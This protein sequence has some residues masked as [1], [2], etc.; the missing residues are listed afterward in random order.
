MEHTYISLPHL[1]PCIRG[2]MVY[3][4]FVY[5]SKFAEILRFLKHLGV[6]QSLGQPHY[7]HQVLLDDPASRHQAVKVGE[8][9]VI[10]RLPCGEHVPNICQVFPVL[11]CFLFALQIFLTSFFLNSL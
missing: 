3:N 10:A 11:C 9:H 5:F 2:A 1:R 7:E 8:T 6:C 4:H